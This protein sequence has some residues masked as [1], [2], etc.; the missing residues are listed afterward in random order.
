M[1]GYEE[2]SV[3]D[4]FTKEPSPDHLRALLTFHQD[5]AFNICYQL[6]HSREDAEDAAQE[7]LIKLIDDLTRIR[8]SHA[9][10]HWLYRICL[11][12]ALHLKRGRLRRQS[13]ELRYAMLSES[14]DHPPEQSP[15]DERTALFQALERLKEGE[16]GLLMEH[17]FE[18]ILLEQI[19]QR[20][21]ISRGMIWKRAE[22]ARQNLRQ[23]LLAMGTGVV[24]HDPASLLEAC[25]PITLST[26]LVPGAMAH[27]ASGSVLAA[28]YL[29][30]TVV[31]TKATFSGMTLLAILLALCLGGTA[32]YTARRS[33][34]SQQKL[35]EL[36]NRLIAMNRDLVGA[37]AEVESLHRVTPPTPESDGSRM[38]GGKEQTKD[39]KGAWRQP[40]IP[41]QE[42]ARET[43]RPDQIHHF[44]H[45]VASRLILHVENARA[46]LK[47]N[48]VNGKFKVRRSTFNVRP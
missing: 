10:R 9:L 22:R 44:R 4:T 11:T 17:Y 15:G 19:A 2:E 12:K 21:G 24:V 31:A 7:A 37:R 30:G 5:R 38:S 43:R 13:R 41:G 20:D 27:A 29:G 8:T 23:T 28:T 36:E 26:N 16:R 1:L 40:A 32:G 18:K 42:R 48:G 46:S 25:Q 35:R 34:S 6:L 45:S 33:D 39:E 14:L 47:R 3:F